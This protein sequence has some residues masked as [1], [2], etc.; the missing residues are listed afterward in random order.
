M[1]LGIPG[2]VVRTYREHD[3]LMGKIDFGGV[4]KQVCL[5]HVPDV[6]IGQYVLVHVGFALSKID[7]DEA[8]RVFEFLEG[9]NQLDELNVPG[10]DETEG[11]FP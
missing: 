8:G 10:P 6:Q 1:C 11:R 9:M 2:K 5:E 4:S 7:E 3:V